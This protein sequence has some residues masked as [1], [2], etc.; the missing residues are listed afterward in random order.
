MK[1]QSCRAPRLSALLL[2][3]DFDY[4][5]PACAAHATAAERD[6]HRAVLARERERL[7]EYHRSIPVECWSWPVMDEHKVRAE[8]ARTCDDPKE[9]RRLAWVLL[10]QWQDG[11]CAIC[12][13]PAER[14]DHDHVT[15]LVRGWLCHCCN[16]GEGFADLPGGHFERY[17]AKN[18][19]S[20]LGIEIRYY[21]PFNGWAEPQP[22]RT[23]LDDH[24]AY[25]LATRFGARSSAA[26]QGNGA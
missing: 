13:S 6:E 18:P 15:A 5:S 4:Q 8:A 25:V 2:M 19:A 3:G 20:I 14:L 22:E 21:D 12:G 10:A 11:R 23:S 1:G 9:A 26:Q 7:H 17:R 16:V 24:P